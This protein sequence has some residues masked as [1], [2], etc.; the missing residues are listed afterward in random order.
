MIEILSNLLPVTVGAVLG[1]LSSVITRRFEW[2][3]ERRKALQ[4]QQCTL[5]GDIASF[6]Y[7]LLAFV[8]EDSDISKE[9]N[10][11]V[12][13]SD[14]ACWGEIEQRWREI[15]PRLWLLDRSHREK[16]RELYHNISEQS[17]D[18][19]YQSVLEETENF[20]NSLREYIYY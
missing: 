2:K 12:P 20:I 18:C 10:G 15:E 8:G 6:L 14:D 16:V 17:H 13:R 9:I 4:D 3:Y 11:V 5:C 1:F 7:A 19:R